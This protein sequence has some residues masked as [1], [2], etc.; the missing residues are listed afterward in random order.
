MA[1][2]LKLP[3][4]IL[5]IITKELTY[6]SLLSL[7][8]TC[9]FFRN[10][11]SLPRPNCTIQDLLEIEI[12]AKYHPARDRPLE[13]QH[14]TADDYFACSRCLKIKSSDNFSDAM[15]KGSRGKFA[16]GMWINKDTRF[17]ISCGINNEIYIPSTKLFYG[18]GRRNY[19]FV[20]NVCSRFEGV[21]VID[22]VHRN[23]LVADRKSVV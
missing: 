22:S 12:W 4:E 6:A 19:G 16:N 18:G 14:P 7:R 8:M 9:R 10:L 5:L 2:I 20:C 15:M 23:E 1:K 13:S 3:T 21:E 11:L 17:C